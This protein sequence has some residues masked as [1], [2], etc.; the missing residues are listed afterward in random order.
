M[1]FFCRHGMMQSSRGGRW[2]L[3]YVLCKSKQRRVSFA[4]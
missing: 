4:E 1:A 3:T 2:M